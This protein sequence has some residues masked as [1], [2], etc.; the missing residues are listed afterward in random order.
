MSETE[1]LAEINTALKAIDNACNAIQYDDR[2]RY[3]VE[4]IEPLRDVAKLINKLVFQQGADVVITAPPHWRCFHCDEVFYDTNA[5]KLHFGMDQCSDPACKIKMGAEGSLVKALRQSESELAD[6][7][8][9]I[10]NE[11]TEAAKAYYAQQSRHGDQLRAAEEA[12]Y[13]R[14]LADGRAEG[15]LRIETRT[16]KCEI[17]GGPHD[18][19]VLTDICTYCE[20]RINEEGSP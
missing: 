8:A 7:W 6:A 20:A 3:G 12:G 5:A 18:N 19:D 17:C 14:G 10:H 9:V 2:G 1:E 4:I 13:E 11:S 15:G 16:S